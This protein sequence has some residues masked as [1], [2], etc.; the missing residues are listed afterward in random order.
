MSQTEK[1]IENAG[2]PHDAVDLIAKRGK[3]P[4][5]A[6]IHAIVERSRR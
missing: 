5:S 6:Y 2:N 3:C 4:S 1:I